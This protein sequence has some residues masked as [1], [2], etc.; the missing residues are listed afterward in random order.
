MITY[1]R[2]DSILNNRILRN[3]LFSLVTAVADKPLFNFNEN[4]SELLLLIKHV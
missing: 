2:N 4:K 1:E 3:S